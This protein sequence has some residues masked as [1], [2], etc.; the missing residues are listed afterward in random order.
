MSNRDYGDMFGG[1]ALVAIGAFIA[2]YAVTTL[3]LGTVSRMGPGMFPAALGV[4]LAV[5]GAVILIP[6]LFREGEA[7]KVEPRS[8]ISVT[9]AM[10]AFVLLVEPFGLVPAIVVLTLIAT[11]ADGKLGWL[12]SAILAV[13]LAGGAVL[14][15]QVGLD[16]Q[17]PTLNW[18]W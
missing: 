6:A 17:L 1:G 15:F 9:T 12:G 10:L 3:S 14:I 2:Y 5:L 18:P 11:C 8:L 13:V 7:L 16:L 4:I